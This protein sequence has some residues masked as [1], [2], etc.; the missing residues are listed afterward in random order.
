LSVVAT[1]TRSAALDRD[2]DVVAGPRADE[3]RRH[4]HPAPAHHLR[5]AR[6]DE[7]LNRQAVLRVDALVVRHEE[8]Q[9]GERD[10]AETHVERNQRR[11]RLRAHRHARCEHH[12]CNG[13]K[14][15][16]EE[17]TRHVPTI[18]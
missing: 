12:R 13:R 6:G 15:T 10:V 3:L 8:D 5:G 17:A 4:D 9:L 7:L 16:G 14:E 11:R 18:T 2:R 1:I